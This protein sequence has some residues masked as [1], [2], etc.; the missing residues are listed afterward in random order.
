MDKTISEKQCSKC[1]RTFPATLE[2]FQSQKQRNRKDGLHS[3]C[4]E[5]K[6]IDSRKRSKDYYQAHR[7][8]IIADVKKRD[9]VDPEKQRARHKKWYLDHKELSSQRVKKNAKD[10]RLLVITHYGGHCQC[11]GESRLE[12]LA[13]DHIAGGGNKHLAVIGRGN[14]YRWLRDNDFPEGFRVLC[15]NCNMA[16]GFYGYCPHTFS[17]LSN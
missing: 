1:K 5:C 14:L 7:E 10:L 11:C 16:L 4:K 17:P 15:H 8:K 2:Y 12:F 3:W 6:H 9:Q 13:I